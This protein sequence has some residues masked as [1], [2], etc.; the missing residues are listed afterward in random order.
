MLSASKYRGTLVGA[1]LDGGVSPDAA[2]CAGD[3]K[4]L[5]D[6]SR[7]TGLP[8]GMRPALWN[9]EASLAG[10]APA[11]HHFS[12]LMVVSR[13]FSSCSFFASASSRRLP[14]VS[15]PIT[16]Q[17]VA[18]FVGVPMFLGR[19]SQAFVASCGAVQRMEM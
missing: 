2:P 16:W 9:L 14:M 5:T 11:D 17:K 13:V 10:A 18:Y 7:N 8:H 19:T 3:L 15:T 4:V 1:A 6:P 12:R